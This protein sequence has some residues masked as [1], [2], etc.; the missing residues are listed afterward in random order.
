M[1]NRCYILKLTRGASFFLKKSVAIPRFDKHA[2]CIY[3]LNGSSVVLY[4]MII[5]LDGIKIMKFE[6][7]DD[8]TLND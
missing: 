7:F 5:N 6:A 8:E 4:Y 2:G 3:R 1:N